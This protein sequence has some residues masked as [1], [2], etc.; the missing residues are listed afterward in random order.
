MT[1]PQNIALTEGLM[2]LGIQHGARA[3][4]FL[5][6]NTGDF[7]VGTLPALTAWARQEQSQMTPQGA[8]A[9]PSRRRRRS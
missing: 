9:T 1:E 7:D 5:D 6:A 8:A 2:Q 4:A 3:Q